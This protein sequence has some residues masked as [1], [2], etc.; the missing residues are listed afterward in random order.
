MCGITL[1]CGMQA[2]LSHEE[3][4][5]L[6]KFYQTD[7]GRVRYKEF[8]HLMENGEPEITLQNQKRTE[9]NCS[10]SV[11]FNTIIPLKQASKK[12]F[13]VEFNIIVKSGSILITSNQNLIFLKILK[14]HFEPHLLP[15]F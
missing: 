11:F 8:C 6:V 15:R 14:I 4:D 12:I 5:L 13:I 9:K 10:V 3:I 1:C 7:D 2:N